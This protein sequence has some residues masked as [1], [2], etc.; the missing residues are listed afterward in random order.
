MALSTS[1][2]HNYP[3]FFFFFFCTACS[4]GIVRCQT[5][6]AN[7]FLS[8]A[9]EN[10]PQPLND[11]KYAQTTLSWLEQ[12]KRWPG[13]LRH[14]ETDAIGLTLLVRLK[15]TLKNAKLTIMTYRCRSSKSLKT[16][17]CSARPSSSSA[18]F[19]VSSVAERHALLFVFC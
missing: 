6:S 3:F 17:T 12:E 18:T 2:F 7:F 4:S 8:F 16:A 9:N 14:L 5:L 10:M 19:I 1:V 15:C 13:S 11:L